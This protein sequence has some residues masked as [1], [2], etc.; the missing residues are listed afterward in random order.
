L[1]KRL[2]A[3]EDKTEMLAMQLDSFSHDTRTQLKQLFNTIREMMT[4]PDPPDPPERPIGFVP[5]EDKS[6]GKKAARGQKAN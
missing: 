3:L 2:C 6:N 5:P 4:P 1:A